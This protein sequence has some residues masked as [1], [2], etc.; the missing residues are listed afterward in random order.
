MIRW[1]SV[2]TSAATCLVLLLS[3]TPSRALTPQ[4]TI[5]DLVGKWACTTRLSNGQ[6]WHDT[7]ANS[8][9]G[10]WLRMSVS[11]PPQNQQSGGTS[12]KFLG[13]DDARKQ[14]IVMSVDDSGDYYLMHSASP[15]FDGSRWI[16]AYPPDGLTGDVHVVNPDSYTF[17]SEKRG[18]HGLI[19]ISQT[20]CVRL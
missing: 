13:H 1:C 3:V 14:W 12:I 19:P 15:A 4:Q 6:T 16:D 18:A 5:H 17:D 7:T 20:T 10:S 8:T 11:F 2:P 9:F